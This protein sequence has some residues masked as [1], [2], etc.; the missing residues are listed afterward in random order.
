M[1]NFYNVLWQLTEHQQRLSKE[2]PVEVQWL[3][4]V[5]LNTS[6]KV[7]E[8]LGII[9]NVSGLHSVLDIQQ[10]ADLVLN[11]DC[12]WSTEEFVENLIRSLKKPL[13]DN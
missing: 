5:Q 8:L 2:S 9:R 6:Q 10:V 12:F 7:Q 3:Q 11:G 13:T 1:F 4:T